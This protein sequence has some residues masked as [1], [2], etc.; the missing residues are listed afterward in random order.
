MIEGHN[1]LIE[2]ISNWINVSELFFPW[3]NIEYQEIVSFST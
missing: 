3:I 2:S 1:L